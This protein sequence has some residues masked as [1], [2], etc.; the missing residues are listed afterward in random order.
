MPTATFYRLPTEKRARLVQAAYREFARAPFP[1]A[2]VSNIIR[3]AEVAHGS[4]YQYFQDKA[5]IFDYL[6]GL[7]QNYNLKWMREVLRQEDNDF[8]AAIAIV[9]DR[10][11]TAMTS[12]PYADYYANVFLYLDVRTP[13]QL[14]MDRRHPQVGA[15][16]YLCEHVDRSRL[17]VNGDIDVALLI[18][19]V[20]GMFVQTISAYY[21]SLRV[22]DAPSP[23][24]LK[25]QVAMQ[26]RWLAEGAGKNP[27][28]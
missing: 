28:E 20:M 16:A 3:N 18:W 8:F 26:L 10:L 9:F 25:Q 22:G 6:L 4:F 24:E 27:P 15:A 7:Q 12:G 21:A 19:Q 2:S 17:K 11:I 5:D 14:G 1:E 13:E 23:A